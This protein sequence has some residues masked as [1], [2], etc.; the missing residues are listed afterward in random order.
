MFEIAHRCWSEGDNDNSIKSIEK[1]FLTNLDGV[2]IDVRWSDKRQVLVAGHFEE[3]EDLA[4]SLDD[5]LKFITTKNFK[6]LLLD[7]KE[8]NKNI[9]QTL[10][11]LIQKNSISCEVFVFGFRDVMLNFPWKK[12]EDFKFS[13]GLISPYP[14]QLIKDLLF[15]RPDFISFGHDERLWT[16]M[17][18]K[19]VIPRFLIKTLIKLFSKTKFILG[20]ARGKKQIEYFKSIKNLFGF[21]VD[22]NFE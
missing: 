17:V 1:S 16:R 6:I 9:L 21:T 3:G 5:V 7:L 4:E 18:F 8:I 10:D 13:V 22:K 15:L 11:M 12:K 19:V 14:W 2:E 20:I